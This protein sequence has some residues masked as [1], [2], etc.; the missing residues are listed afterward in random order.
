MSF[1]IRVIAW[2]FGISVAWLNTGLLLC[3]DT[4]NEAVNMKGFIRDTDS[5]FPMGKRWALIIGVNYT[6]NQRPSGEGTIVSLQHAEND[7]TEFERVL[8]EHYGYQSDHIRILTGKE[9]TQRA[10]VDAL[11]EGWLCSDQIAENDSVLIY[12]SGHGSE[13]RDKGGNEVYNGY[14]WP[15]DTAVQSDGT[16]RTA[17]AVSLNEQVEH[18][19]RWCKARQKLLILDCCNAGSVYAN[20]FNASANDVD[21]QPRRNVLLS[22]TFQVLSASRHGEN[23]VD[24]DSY[25]Q[26]LLKALRLIPSKIAPHSELGVRVISTSHLWQASRTFFKS[27]KVAQSPQCKWLGVGGDGE[28]P[29]FPDPSHPFPSEN[30]AEQEQAL[31]L[32]MVPSTFGNWWMEESPWFMP[33][34]RCQILANVTKTRSFEDNLS[35]NS[36]RS[37]AEKLGV[38]FTPTQ[39]L[40]R[41]F[42]HMKEL[43]G[44][45]SSRESKRIMKKIAGELMEIC[46]AQSESSS[47]TFD[48][49]DRHF[50]ANLAH[51]LKEREEAER[52]YKEAINEYDS[53]LESPSGHDPWLRPLKALC[54]LDYGYF[55]LSEK[56]PIQK[57]API[58]SE[59]EQPS[60]VSPKPVQVL[61]SRI[62]LCQDAAA[63]FREAQSVL[64]SLAPWRFRVFAMIQEAKAVREAGRWAKA[65]DLVESAIRIQKQFN[66][67]ARGL[68]PVSRPVICRNRV[69][70]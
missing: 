65:D 69:P 55:L 46:N 18:I 52:H 14:L 47:G 9:A 64:V 21:Y 56:H 13:Q 11:R 66:P 29:F 63:K 50:M 3:Q 42:G 37:A 30:D 15:V 59:D 17:T 43:L 54:L 32:A 44:A 6:A 10:I 8:R 68:S 49:L 40:S 62:L 38:Q 25:T 51:S 20:G 57:A 53:L 12:F 4:E 23:A 36:L 70:P 61:N 28:F 22:P 34:L 27:E 60:E 24:K 19:K 33:G 2:I 67:I 16:L 45:N 58:A 35:L 41:R 26:S 5:S 48:V 31:L 7:A 1:F 39:A